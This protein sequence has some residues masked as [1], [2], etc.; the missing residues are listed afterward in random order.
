MTSTGCTS[1]QP[2]SGDSGVPGGNAGALRCGA[3]FA[4]PAAAPA[5]GLKPFEQPSAF[6]QIA[7]NGE[8]MVTIN[9]LEFGQGCVHVARQA[10]HAARLG[11][12][13]PVTGRHLVFDSELPTEMAELIDRIAH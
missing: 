4:L 3:R 5:A 1:S 11:F 12:V 10:L 9:R 2:S 13:H 6:V 8:V 7:P